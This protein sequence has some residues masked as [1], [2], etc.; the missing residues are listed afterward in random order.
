YDMECQKRACEI[1]PVYTGYAGTGFAFQYFGYQCGIET[2][3]A[4]GTY[5]GLPLVFFWNT[6]YRSD[7]KTCD[8]KY[9]FEFGPL[10]I[11]IVIVL[12]Y[13]IQKTRDL[14]RLWISYDMAKLSGEKA[15]AWE[16][17]RA[18]FIRKKGKLTRYDEQIIAS[19][20]GMKEE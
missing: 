17:G 6:Y 16:L 5:L 12:M 13:Y 7:V 19:D 8:M 18:F 3:A 14:Y 10:I 4:G 9:I 20:L 1:M 2:D 11:G 15:K